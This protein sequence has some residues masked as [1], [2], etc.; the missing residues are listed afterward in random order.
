MAWGAVVAMA[1]AA[2]GVVAYIVGP[3]SHAPN[4]PCAFSGTGSGRT[5]QGD[6]STFFIVFTSPP[7]GIIYF[8]DEGPAS[9][10]QL[11]DRHVSTVTC[12]VHA[13][14]GT[15]TETVGLRSGTSHALGFRIDLGVPD[16]T[17]AHPTIRVR[18]TD[19]Y[20]SGTETLTS[21]NVAIKSHG[22]SRQAVVTG[23]PIQK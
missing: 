1:Y 12:T 3:A 10:L 7:T 15:V 13:S 8:T 18:L 16:G 19:G 22:L 2:L 6:K 9:P 20:D 17:G 11:R 23:S 4:T 21:A 14:T 5:A